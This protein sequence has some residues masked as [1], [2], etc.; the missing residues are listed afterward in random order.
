MS[1]SVSSLLQFTLAKVTKFGTVQTDLSTILFV[2]HKKTVYA[3]YLLTL[4]MLRSRIFEIKSLS[5]QS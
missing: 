3:K 5:L 1:K 2:F 4:S